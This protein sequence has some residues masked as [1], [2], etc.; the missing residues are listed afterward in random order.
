[1]KKKTISRIACLMAVGLAACVAKP[2]FFAHSEKNEDGT[3]NI[4]EDNRETLLGIKDPDDYFLGAASQFS[5]FLNG[6]FEADQSDC[7]GRLAAAGNANM[8]PETPYYSVGAKL[9]N[10]GDI[11]HVVIGGDTLIN[12]SAGSKNFV[13]GEKLTV[14]GEIA[15]YMENGNCKVYVGELFDFEEE[16]QRLNDRAEFLTEQDDNAELIID[17]YYEKGWTIKGEDTNLNVIS[18]DADQAK[19]FTDGYIDLTL[20]I[21][22]GSYIVI[23]VPGTHVEMPSTQVSIIDA[24]GQKTPTFENTPL[25]YNL[26]EATSFHYTGSIQGSTLAPNADAT[27]EQG[28]HVAGATIAKT[29]KGGIQFGYSKFDP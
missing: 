29:F 26:Y 11:A 1:M 28:G 5:V 18:L 27:G 13:M 7:E 23:N 16:F 19:I 6:D 2:V 21:P 22:D 14:G 17:Q 15:T 25:L 3:Y 10:A 4:T 9:E 12:F 20:D 24:D 8:G